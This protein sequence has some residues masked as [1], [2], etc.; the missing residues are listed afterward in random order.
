MTA[1]R[2]TAT[3]ESEQVTDPEFL[4][5]I[6]QA[7]MGKYSDSIEEDISNALMESAE[8][9]AEPDFDPRDD[10]DDFDFDDRF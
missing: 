7:F 8:S 1:T 9:D 10:Y 4:L 3:G 2:E 5:R 6:R